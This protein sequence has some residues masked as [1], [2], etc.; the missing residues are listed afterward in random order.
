MKMKR[1][2]PGVAIALALANGAAF[3]QQSPSRNEEVWGNLAHQPT[4]SQVQ[5]AESA[6]GVAPPPQAQRNIDS[7]L[8]QLDKQIQGRAQQDLRYG[9]AP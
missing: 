1:M 5:G 4:E 9:P 6:A 3:A 2:G 7:E 8:Q